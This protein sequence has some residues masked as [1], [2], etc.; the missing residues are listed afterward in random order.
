M[1]PV[2]S[3]RLNMGS[4]VL[5][6]TYTMDIVGSAVIGGTSMLGGK[7]KIIHAALGVLFFTVL[8][9][10]LS[11]MRLDTFTVQ[12]IKGAVILVAATLDVLRVNIQRRSS[13]QMSES[14]VKAGEKI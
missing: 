12:V 2:Y 8:S 5:G 3:A 9:T 13:V 1:P 6:S 14:A 10:A 7:G 11:Q 4:P